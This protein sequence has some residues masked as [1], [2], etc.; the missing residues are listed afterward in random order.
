MVAAAVIALMYCGH[1]VKSVQDRNM[2]YKRM[3]YEMEVKLKM[4]GCQ[5]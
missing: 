5:R 4:A 3:Q 1:C 2:E